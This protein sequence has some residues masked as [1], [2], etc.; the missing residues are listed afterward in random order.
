MSN[1]EDDGFKMLSRTH[2]FSGGV[3]LDR[4]V[5]FRGDPDID[6]SQFRPL[7]KAGKFA[8]LLL[9]TLEFIGFS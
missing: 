3:R 5:S 6:D 1:F 4:K 7:A 8:K 2:S 9:I